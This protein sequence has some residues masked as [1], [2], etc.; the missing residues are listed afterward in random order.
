MVYRLQ[1][2]EGRLS[3]RSH[4]YRRASQVA[5][6]TVAGALIL[7]IVGCANQPL[8]KTSREDKIAIGAI[9]GAIV[10]GLIGYEAIGSGDGRYLSAIILGTA[11]AYGGSILADRLTRWDK[12]A[13]H[14]TT[15]ESLSESPSGETS[16]WSN[17]SSGNSGSI[18][19]IRTYLDEEGR[20]CREYNAS[21]IVD[22]EVVEGTETA[23]R[24][25]TGAWI[26]RS[27]PI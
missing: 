5:R 6:K 4:A 21:L 10:G 18:T 16:K 3:R 13:M 20:I 27:T 2:T 8:N 9:A 14:E 24:T 7:G 23:C 11:G 17:S 22:G 15:Y 19:P 1:M 26:I 25:E 12:T